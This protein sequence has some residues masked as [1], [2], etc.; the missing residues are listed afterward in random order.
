MSRCREDKRFQS[1]VAM[2]T[3]QDS[4]FETARLVERTLPNGTVLRLKLEPL[5]GETVKVSEYHRK[6]FGTKW[7]RLPEEEGRVVRFDQLKL[8]S[9]FAEVFTTF[10]NE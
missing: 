3:F 6:V 7:Q 10:G 8:T 9:S 4:L 5:L 2:T 1:S